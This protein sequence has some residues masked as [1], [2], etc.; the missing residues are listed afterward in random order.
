MVFYYVQ[1][2]LELKK[3][4]PFST[5]FW[6]KLVHLLKKA[7]Y[8]L[9]FEDPTF[10]KLLDVWK[11]SWMAELLNNMNIWMVFYYAQQF[12]GLKK[13]TKNPFSTFLWVKLVH[14]L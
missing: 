1:Q 12:L 11:K 8:K 14:L 4:K 6:V 3:K 5:F 9:K 2:F 10:S 7:I 13:K